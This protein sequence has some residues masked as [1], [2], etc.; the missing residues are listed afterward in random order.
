MRRPGSSAIA[1]ALVLLVTALLAGQ[2][3][4]NR[5]HKEGSPEPA[6]ISLILYRYFGGCADEYAHVT[7]LAHAVGECGVIQVLTNQ[8]NAMHA[9]KIQ[10]RT[11]TAE[12]GG[13]YDRLSATYAARRPPDI[14]V[15]N[16]SVLPSFVCRQLVL[17]L[18]NALVRAG[19][20]LEDLNASARKGATF[21][22]E[23]FALPYDL[24]GLLWHLNLDIL[25]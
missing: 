24:H 7:D 11:Q 10:V 22:V 20:A 18:S 5:S 2:V 17:P 8:F 19:V 3:L 23:L 12:W 13:Y 6:P 9:G 21:E 25:E 14:A 1:S 4:L 16:R 15:M